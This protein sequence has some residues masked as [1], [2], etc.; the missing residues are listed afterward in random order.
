MANTAAVVSTGQ[1][2]I[3]EVAEQ[4]VEI[5]TPGTPAL[6]EIAVEGPQGIQGPPGSATPLSG[7]PDV[8][9]QSAVDKS[10]LFYDAAT[11]LW[12]GND[13]NTTITLTD[14]GAF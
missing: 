8:N 4:V 2:I 6:V 13:V 10:V 1:I 11:Q 12:V 14:G 3:T 9:T 7:L 5:T